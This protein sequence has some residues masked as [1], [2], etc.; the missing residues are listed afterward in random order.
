MRNLYI[1]HTN[2]KPQGASFPNIGT[3]DELELIHDWLKVN[4]I[5][6][7]YKFD[8]N[9]EFCHVELDKNI[10]IT[11]QKIDLVAPKNIYDYA[12]VSDYAD[13][14]ISSYNEI[15]S[16]SYKEIK[17]SKYDYNL[18][19]EGESYKYIPE[20]NKETT[21]AGKRKAMDKWYQDNINSFKKLKVSID[22]RTQCETC[23]LNNT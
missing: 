22:H 8:Y 14:N 7:Q 23:R 18:L 5:S 1:I 20:V 11:I 9:Y 13:F 17:N 10:K 12:I 16:L 15:V 19:Y 2:L 3:H 4:D 21:I 6:N